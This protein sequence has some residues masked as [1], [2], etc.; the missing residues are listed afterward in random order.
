[1]ANAVE[2]CSWLLAGIMSLM[3]HGVTGYAG[4]T[5][6]LSLWVLKQKNKVYTYKQKNAKTAT[7]FIEVNCVTV[8][9]TI[10]ACQFRLWNA[11]WNKNA[12][13]DL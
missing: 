5:S 13:A 3:L 6:R 9:E 4:T 8:W 12:C 10:I 2:Y 1:L 11:R 7:K